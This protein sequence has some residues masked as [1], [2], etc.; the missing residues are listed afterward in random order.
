M[1]AVGTEVYVVLGRCRMV[2]TTLACNL[3]W[4]YNSFVLSHYTSSFSVSPSLVSKLVRRR[5]SLCSSYL[6][7]SAK[8]S[9]AQLTT[10]HTFL[11]II[12][13]HLG[14]FVD[15]ALAMITAVAL[16]SIS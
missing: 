13:V 2:A 8:V 3:I 16:R 10:W 1:P 15:V 7:V 5:L 9:T 4:P 11:A 6:G 14:S 12:V